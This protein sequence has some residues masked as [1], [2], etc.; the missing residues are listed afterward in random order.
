MQPFPGPFIGSSLANTWDAAWSAIGSR[1]PEGLRSA[2]EGA[3]AETHRHYH[4]LRHLGECMALWSSWGRNAK[5]PGE[6]GIALWFHDAVYDPHASDN[7]IESAAWAERSLE[8]AGAP[9]EVVQRICTLI[10]AT[11]HG[12]PVEGPDAELVVD[13]DLAILGSP[14]DRFRRYDQDI[15]KEYSWVPEDQFNAKRSALLR[16]FAERPRIYH[17]PPA[18]ELLEERARNNLETAIAKLAGG[19]QAPG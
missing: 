3:W 12:E 6:V 15:R 5:R 7:E 2:L 18:V 9:G 4:D 10:M 13:I 14:A 1:P 16:G 11:R 19:A 17:C 8:A